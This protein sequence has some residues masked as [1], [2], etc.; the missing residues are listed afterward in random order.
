MGRHLIL[1]LGLLLFAG[2]PGAAHAQRAVNLYTARHYESDQ[3]LYD[4]FEKETGIKVNAVSGNAPELIERIR[5]EGGATSA[6]LF[7]TVD[8]GVLR[9]AK[10]AGILSPVTSEK[11]LANVPQNRRDRD[12]QWLGLT[13]RARVIVYS[14]E[15][16]RAEEL[17]TYEALADPKWQGRIL[18][19]PS[20]SLYDQS[21]L[22]SLI[23]LDGENEAAAWVKGFAGNFARPPKGNDRA[24]AKDIAAGLGDVA[25]MNT[26]YIGQMLN[27]KDP[28]EV[29][30]VEAVG[31]FFPS[32]A[33]TG[34]HINIS[35]VGLVKNGPNRD[36]AVKLIEFLTDVEAQ[37]RLSADNYEYPVNPRARTHEFLASFG[38]FKT[39]DIDFDDLG[40]NNALAIRLFAQGGWK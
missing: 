6:D 18:A 10:E 3:V 21:L 38:D 36:N 4:L 20:S 9:T 25:L 8:G 7:I 15:R 30:A 26:Y 28:E 11:A 24:Q 33:G 17:S 29:R 19:R 39:Q 37:N 27:S 1:F 40:R 13:T 31:V 22:A 16:V 34:T 35:G 2:P 14:K 32:Q 12:N 5:R 23:V